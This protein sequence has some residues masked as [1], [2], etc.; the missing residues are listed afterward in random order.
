LV[1]VFVYGTVPNKILTLCFSKKLQKI[2][3]LA[4]SRKI[5]LEEQQQQ[6][7]QQQQ[8][9]GGVS[10]EQCKIELKEKSLRRLIL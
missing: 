8:Q 9:P 1:S 4:R 3:V 2:A 5:Q 10:T 7:Q 6:Q